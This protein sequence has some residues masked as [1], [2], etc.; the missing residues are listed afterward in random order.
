MNQKKSSPVEIVV[1]LGRSWEWL[2][3][4]HQTL[5]KVQDQPMLIEG[6]GGLLP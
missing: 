5:K 6:G 3:F 4:I 2:Q 1:V